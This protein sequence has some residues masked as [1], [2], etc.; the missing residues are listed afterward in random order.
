M[1]TLEP[2]SDG[3]KGWADFLIDFNDFASGL[4]GV[5]TFNQTRALKVQHID[6]AFGDRARLF[7]GLRQRTDALN[8]LHNSYFANLL[9]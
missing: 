6:K 8:R 7:K 9:G 3:E 1:V 2:S 5:P 4:G